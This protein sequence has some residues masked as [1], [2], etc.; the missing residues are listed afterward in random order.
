MQTYSNHADHVGAA[1][2]RFCNREVL[3]QG[4][5]DIKC[6]PLPYKVS[7]GPAPD[8]EIS[9]G[10]CSGLSAQF[11]YERFCNQQESSTLRAVE[12]LPV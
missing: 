3:L 4:E 2:S 1:E 7:R 11:H 6:L 5:T 12:Q 9:P 8:V 10:D